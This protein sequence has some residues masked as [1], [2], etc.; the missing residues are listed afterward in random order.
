MFSDTTSV[1]KRPAFATGGHLLGSSSA[2]DL[3]SNSSPSESVRNIWAN[4]FID[5]KIDDDKP[6]KN[7]GNSGKN[8]N[9]TK[10]T[11]A[12]EKWEEIDDDILIHSVKNTVI[13]I[14]DGSNDS[15]SS[16][17]SQANDEPMVHHSTNQAK[18]QISIKR[19]LLDDLGI[20]NLHHIV[21]I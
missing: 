14:D 16:R 13:E 8:N 9:K 3:S 1:I 20:H 10:V 18:S 15:Q 4:K 12:S 21:F 2:H 19:E 17:K 11:E 7:G 5:S 6:E